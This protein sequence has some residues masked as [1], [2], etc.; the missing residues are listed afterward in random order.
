M[1]FEKIELEAYG[2]LD[3]ILSL[4]V[5]EHD[6]DSAII[7][8]E[9]LFDAMRMQYEVTSTERSNW[10]DFY[11]ELTVFEDR[12]DLFRVSI[13][14]SGNLVSVHAFYVSSAQLKKLAKN[15]QTKIVTSSTSQNR[16]IQ[17]VVRISL[18]EE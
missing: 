15:L 8:S 18:F 3:E 11:A 9:T 2:D 4:Y 10:I 1:T 7:V 6:A 13:N 17:K 14:I 12:A 16:W 5:S